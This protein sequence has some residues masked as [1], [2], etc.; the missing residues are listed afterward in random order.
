MVADSIM[1]D[2]TPVSLEGHK[3]D[4]SEIQNLDVG[5]KNVIE[6]IQV[7]GTTITPT[8]KVVNLSG[9]ATQEYVSNELTEHSQSII[10]DVTNIVGGNA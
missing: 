1:V 2:G 4:V 10:N 5:D 8:N 7:N 3:H 9:I 6:G